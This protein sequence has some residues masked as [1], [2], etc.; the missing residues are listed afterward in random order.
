VS[1]TDPDNTSLIVAITVPLILI[2]I[3]FVTIIFLRRRRSSARKTTDQRANDN[4]SLPD[5][6]IETSRP[7]LIKN[8]A[9]HYRLMSA[10]SDFR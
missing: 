6:T 9:E 8:F 10:D 4:M 5:S 3:V 7:V 2:F 1:S